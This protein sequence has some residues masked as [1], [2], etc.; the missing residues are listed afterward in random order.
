M[1]NVIEMTPMPHL[2]SPRTPRRPSRLKTTAD[3]RRLLCE[4]RLRPPS[5]RAFLRKFLKRATHTDASMVFPVHIP[6]VSP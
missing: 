5:Q 6:V 3:F 4:M 1:S 2:L